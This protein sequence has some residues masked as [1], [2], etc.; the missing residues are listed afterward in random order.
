MKYETIR[1]AVRAFLSII[2][3][4]TAF[5]ASLY[6][7]PTVRIKEIAYV[8]GVRENQLTGVGLV[9]G[10]SGRGDS[11]SSYLLQK[12]LANLLA[13]FGIEVPHDEVKSSNCAV[14]L[15]SVES[16]AYA[17]P[18]DRID[19]VVSSIGDAK[20]LEGGVLLQT[21]LMAANGRI[22]GTAQG[23]V[24]TAGGKRTGVTAGSIPKGAIVEREI[25]STFITEGAVDIVLRH[26]DFVTAAAVTNA[27]RAAFEGV[28]ITN[29]DPSLI[30]VS[31]PDG[32][33]DNVV[34]FVAELQSVEVTPDSSGKVVIDPHTGVVIMGE[35]VKIGK[36]AVSYREMNVTVG[37]G[38][39]S[40]SYGSYYDRNEKPSTFVIE[41]TT[42]VNDLVEVLAAAGLSTDVIIGILSAIEQA[43]SLYG[44]LIIM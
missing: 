23:K 39:G 13:N 2:I 6:A 31:I 24:L 5:T 17:R 27:I 35:N 42:T 37:S 43:G 41:E 14:V 11:S 22:Y 38:Y 40:S 29:T 4:F 26:P 25:S 19:A 7:A 36:V 44:T 33:Q 20:S 34:G 15:V 9:T 30:R 18:G 12:T 32:R 1:R 16:G 3:L 10:L 21:N 8:G 28:A